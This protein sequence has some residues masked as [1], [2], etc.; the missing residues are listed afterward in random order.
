M[1]ITINDRELTVHGAEYYPP[2]RGYRNSMGVPEEPDE[3]GW[4]EWDFITGE[5]GEE[6]NLTDDEIE[7]VE[8]QLERE[9]D[10]GCR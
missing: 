3:A 6:V 10:D 5:D 1:N 8:I 7:Q 4:W 9:V 2:S